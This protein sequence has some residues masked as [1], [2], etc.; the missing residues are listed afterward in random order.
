[1]NQEVT[2]QAGKANV[3]MVFISFEFFWGDRDCSLCFIIILL[4]AIRHLTVDESTNTFIQHDDT[5]DI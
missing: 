4:F 5:L 1:M 2:P 3:P